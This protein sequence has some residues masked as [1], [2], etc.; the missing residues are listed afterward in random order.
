MNSAHPT[1]MVVDN[2]DNLRDGLSLL[3]RGEG[4]EVLAARSGSEALQK[5]R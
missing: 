2:D 5:L 3:L 1:A 4:F